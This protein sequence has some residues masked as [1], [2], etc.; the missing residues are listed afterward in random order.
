MSHTLTGVYRIGR[1]AELRHIG[2][3]ESVINLSIVTDWGRTKDEDG[4]SPSTW[5]DASLWGKPAEKLV[6]YLL[7]GRQ[8]YL[9]IED[10]HLE[11][12]TNREG[13]TKT[14]LAGRIHTIEL[15]GSK[16]Q[17]NQ[18]QQ[19]PAP[20]QAAPARQAPPPAQRAPSG[21]DDMEDDMVPF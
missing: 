20:R 10:I 21:F 9:V 1:D 15:V 2:S 16:P 11:E 7:K 6:Q 14:K 17:G 12:F 5:I 13:V 18:Q 19:A 4:N 8:V 3:G